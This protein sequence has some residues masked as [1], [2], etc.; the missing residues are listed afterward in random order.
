MYLN[1]YYLLNEHERFH[2]YDTIKSTLTNIR[3]NKTT[4]KYENYELH[5]FY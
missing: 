2:I 4:D 3:F 5:L 1:I